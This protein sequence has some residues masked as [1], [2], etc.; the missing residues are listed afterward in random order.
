MLKHIFYIILFFL[1]LFSISQIT[2]TQTQAD[3]VMIA[4]PELDRKN[5]NMG[6]TSGHSEGYAHDFTL[7]T[8]TSCQKIS[9][10]QVVVTISSYV[11]N[12]PPP[13]CTPDP[14]YYNIY[15]GCGLYTGGATCSTSNLI[16]EQFFP[17]PGSFPNIRT[18]NFG[19]P[20][21]GGGLTAEFGDNFSVDI[22]PVA[23]P[24]CNAITS[25]YVTLQYTIAVTINFGNITCS[26]TGCLAGNKTMQPCD[27]GNSCTINDMQTILNCDG[28]ICI[29]CAGTSIGAPPT[30]TFAQLG[31]YCQN[32]IPGTLPMSSTNASSITGTWSPSTISTST[33]G[34]QIYT[35]TPTV[36]QC[37]TTATMTVNT[38][39]PEMPTFAQL[40]PYCQ[41]TTPGVLPL[42]STNAPPITGTWSPAIISTSTVGPLQYTFTPTAGQC[43]TTA[44][45]D[46]SITSP[47]T[48]TFTLLGPYCQNTTP[49]VLPLSS[50]DAPPIAGTWS[51]AIIS[52]STIGPQVY[53]FTPTAG[54]CGTTATMNITI[55]APPTPTFTPLGPYCQNT[56][57]G[58]LPL[59][60]TDAPPIAGTW[61]PAIIST[62]TIGPQVYTF[63]PT[64]GQCGTTATMN[65]TITAPPTPTFTP[66][67]PFC[68]NTTPD[69]LPLSSTNAPPIA[70][71][72]SPAIIS[73]STIG[74]QVYTFTPT[75]GQC[76]TTT[77]MVIATT[78]PIVT[79]FDQLGPFCQNATPGIL[80]TSSSNLPT[81]SGTWSPSLINTS[82]V[83]SQVYTFT[84][85]AGQCGTQLNMTID[86]TA[87]VLPIFDQLGPYCLNAIPDV[88]PGSSNNSPPIT[89][90]WDLGIINTSFP[91]IT[92]YTFIPSS[93]ECALPTTMT[94]DITNSVLPTFDQL[95][96]FCVNAIP[97]VLPSSSNNS[98]PVTGTWSPGIIN[99]ST[100][101]F[102]DYTF[103]PSTAECA[104][105]TTMTVEVS[106]SAIPTF[107]QLGP[108]CINSTPGLLPAQ[109]NNNINGT[110][111]PSVINTAAMGSFTYTFTPFAGQ[112]GVVTT[113][114]V[115]I[116][117]ALTPTFTQLGP[118]CQNTTPG[119]L[120]LISNNAPSI[121]GTW[122][123]ASISTSTIGTQVYTFTPGSG[124][125]G[126]VTT[127]SITI[128]PPV[129]PTFVQ[130][131]PYCQNSIPGNLPLISTN[132]SPITGT[133][134][135]SVINTAALGSSFYTFTPNIGQCASTTSMMINITTPVTPIFAQLGPY[136]LNSTPGTLPAISNNSQP[137]AGT[138]SPS[139]INTSILG[140]AVYT[141]TPNAGQCA[142]VTTMTIVVTNS[143]TPLFTPMV[144]FCQNETAG[145]LP[146]NS[147]NS[148]SIT[149]TWSPGTVDTSTPGSTIYTFTP[150]PGQC[151][152]STTMTVI[153]SAPRTPEFNQLG[154]YCQNAISGI[155][156]VS[157]NNSPP[158]TGTWSPSFINTST[159]G[160]QI[161]TFSPGFNQ[162]A[163]TT[164]M[165]IEIKTTQTPTFSQLGPYCQNET[166]GVLPDMSTNA[167]P[168]S[169]TW[170]PATINTSTAG[171]QVYTF[172]PNAGQCGT[173]VT[174]NITVTAPNLPTFGQLGP[175]CLDATPGLLPTSSTNALPITGTWSPAV[176]NTSVLG[177]TVY[178]FNPSAGQ[179][180]LPT[181][182][183]IVVSNSI[184]PTFSQLG[185]YCINSTPG[186]LTPVSSNGITGS[187]SPSTINTA[188][189]GPSVYTFTP[190]AGQCG[191]VTTMTVLVTNLVTPTFLSLGP[192]CQNE[193]PGLL[194]MLSTNTLPISGT[195]SPAIVNTS[196]IGTRIY[197]FTPAAGQCGAVTTMSIEIK[198]SVVPVFNQLGPFCQNTTP[199]SLP[200]ISTDLVPISGNWSPAVINTST[201]GSTVYTF[202]PNVGQCASNATMT[203]SITN[204]VTP[205]FSQL[206]P[207]C[208]NTSPGLL[209]SSPSNAPSING[210]WSPSD[211]N[212]SIIGTSVYTFTPA[213]G[214]C[215]SIA[216]MSVTI[217]A[218]PA[219]A[220]SQLGPYCSGETPG[221]LLPTS[222]NIP[223]ITGTWNPGIINTSLV[224]PNVYTFTPTAGQ[225]GATTNMVIT[226]LNGPTSVATIIK[227]TDC[228]QANGAI[229]IGLVNGG[230]SP[231]T[232]NFNNLGFGLTTNFTNVASGSY[233][234]SVRD[235]N[236]CTFNTS[237][238]IVN[239]SGSTCGSNPNCEVI[240]PC[241]DNNP[242]TENDFEIKLLA[243][244][245]ICRPC[246]GVPLP[247]QT[248]LVIV[249]SCDDGDP[250]TI[251]DV[252]T[253]LD[254][255]GS[256]CVPCKGI[257]GSGAVYIPNAF[258]PNGDG[259]NDFFTI[260]GGADVKIIQ[261]FKIYDRWGSNIFS[262]VNIPANDDQAGWDGKYNGSKVGPGVYVYFA[263][264]EFFDGQVKVRNGTI[265]IAW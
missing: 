93:V 129:T 88:L 230:Q 91:G 62:S 28:S 262:A 119:T 63:T 193:T 172:T 76:G 234:L 40:G 224:G 79:T 25:G 102:I 13:G 105:S 90:T 188:V 202:T 186:T 212:T 50:T 143:I 112:C 256:I 116:T 42:S 32:D 199:G 36:G 226:V 207:Y 145:I 4:G 65:I 54:Q 132:S 147:L 92:I 84:P 173:K 164:T 64:A 179:C 22:V 71:T 123:P 182:M 114:T 150:S 81:I 255:D 249:Q 101:G 72:W 180:A 204:P 17:P 19:C 246:A 58:V 162:C 213:N 37:A 45:M 1:P 86:V 134:S 156:P 118:Y 206:G 248:N 106:N 183:T 135:P 30:P 140:S 235:V 111:S 208:Q 247:C 211:I 191:T 141:F 223:P 109:S 68:Q 14:I 217:F 260:Y 228:E 38:T 99:T 231:Y 33:V 51:P 80:S 160:T 210:T 7:P 104:L 85:D 251:D 250:S 82:V 198:A 239:A 169:G 222:S 131:G 195:W 176:I 151:A 61:S 89:G 138:W 178:T 219:P 236:G 60:S 254:C 35:F 41:N 73:T 113:M 130:V 220:F 43:A 232:F 20:L 2:L 155:L 21:N 16:T 57:P 265:T 194:P 9:N 67:G 227:N 69:V 124:Q 55:T 158:I 252:E 142:S 94:V 201:I 170:S 159:V 8:G 70:G 153:I 263:K 95:G 190:N 74:P 127:M 128:T 216:T 29:P 244:G 203:I 238:N 115:V 18:F 181:T 121:T 154:P 258:T 144:I 157:S 225:C 31:P 245:S 23:G 11:L 163:T 125:C 229:T 15:K 197:T 261:E 53:T 148:P 237:V 149:G 24:G 209:P 253:V 133:W 175:Y 47:P 26:S 97:D 87:P 77:T 233:P 167:I 48:P 120:P 187:W 189:T 242:C 110:W 243:D 185:P 174:M 126:T 39:A 83:G 6:S 122:S 108:Y 136:C 34:P 46:I 177:S 196:T 215:A 107:A 192:Y 218:P 3:A 241:N 165:S 257:P 240:L 171:T 152:G 259:N 10:I 205:S 75:A 44:N 96:P 49:G 200:L 12:S 5:W 78:A 117:T 214:Q 98:P 221:I 103:T 168:I 100:V 166:P 184:L 137:V 139:V 56:T 27:D 52:T 264:I 66:L 146:I 161:Y 59:S